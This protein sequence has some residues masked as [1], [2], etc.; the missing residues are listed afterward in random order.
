MYPYPYEIDSSALCGIDGSGACVPIANQGIAYPGQQEILDGSGNL[1]AT[2]WVAPTDAQISNIFSCDRNNDLE[3][4]VQEYLTC[5][6][7]IIE[8][9]VDY[10]TRA[11]NSAQQITKNMQLTKTGTQSMFTSSGSA[12]GL[13][14]AFADKANEAVDTN[15][16][17]GRAVRFAYW[18][19]AVVV[20]LIGLVLFTNS[21]GS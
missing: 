11:N 7:T 9:T 6:S 12:T 3:T 16:N 4:T 8:R 13:F 17:S 14:G 2:E 19:L 18:F 10:A 21:R 15:N 5:I 20:V 1:V